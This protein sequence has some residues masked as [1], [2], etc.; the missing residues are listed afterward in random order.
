MILQVLLLSRHKVGCVCA[1]VMRNQGSPLVPANGTKRH[2][3]YRCCFPEHVPV[4]RDCRCFTV[5]QLPLWQSSGR[6]NAGCSVFRRRGLETGGQQ[7]MAHL[8]PVELQ[9]RL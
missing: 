9:L 8:I 5:L 3:L 2:A 7:R 6:T 1:C 4:L